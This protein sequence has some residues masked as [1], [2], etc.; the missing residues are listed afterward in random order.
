MYVF[1]VLLLNVPLNRVENKFAETINQ[2][3]LQDYIWKMKAERMYKND[4]PTPQAPP[5]NSS[6]WPG[7]NTA[8]QQLHPPESLKGKVGPRSS[9]CIRIREGTS[10]AV[11]GPPRNSQHC[12][13]HR[14]QPQLVS[15]VRAALVC[16][17]SCETRCFTRSSHRQENT[18][19]RWPGPAMVLGHSPTVWPVIQPVSVNSTSF[20]L[21]FLFSLKA[22]LQPILFP[23]L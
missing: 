3:Y 1:K 9:Y 13:S 21:A 16:L 4:R 2:V 7:W 23:L 19:Q 17:L 20:P 10:R 15:S 6:R 8:S 11:R 18:G 12:P 5:R 22:W 14:L